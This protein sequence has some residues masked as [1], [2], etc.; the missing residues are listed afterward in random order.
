MRIR[1]TLPV[2]HRLVKV[3]HT[4]E[5]WKAEPQNS[6]QASNCD[7]THLA[8]ELLRR[9]VPDRK[10]YSHWKTPYISGAQGRE[11]D[12]LGGADERAALRQRI[13]ESA[14]HIRASLVGC[15]VCVCVCAFIIREICYIAIRHNTPLKR[16]CPPEILGPAKGVFCGAKKFLH[17]FFM[18]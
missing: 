15:C 18:I 16:Y 1:V 7:Q 3:Y 12:A 11:E 4:S 13:L 2:R 8:A 14:L 6:A 9:H 10:L 17:L 5:V